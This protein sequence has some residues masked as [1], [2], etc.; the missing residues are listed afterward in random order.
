MND[1]I[2]LLIA[3]MTAVTYIPRL[4]PLILIKGE[5]IPA[6]LRAFLSA[7]PF[8]ALGALLFPDSLTALGKTAPEIL[9]AAAALILAG[10]VSWFTKNILIT[11]VAGVVAAVLWLNL[12]V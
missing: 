2:W 4:L 6:R 11:F 7:V 10:I 5:K 3:G 9:G 1:H 12:V 8:A